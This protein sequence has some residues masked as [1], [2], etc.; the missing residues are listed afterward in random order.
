MIDF[1]DVLL[2]GL[3]IFSFVNWW[4]SSDLR[5]KLARWDKKRRRR[6]A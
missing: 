6:N 1:T 3:L 5:I 4:G 2:S